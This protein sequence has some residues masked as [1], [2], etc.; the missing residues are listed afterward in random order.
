MPVRIVAMAK[1]PWNST[2]KFRRSGDLG[3]A[4]FS[5][6]TWRWW[7]RKVGAEFVLLE[8][9]LGGEG[10]HNIPPTV[11]RWLALQDLFTC[12]GSDAQIAM[13]DADTMV[14]WD[15]PD[16][17]AFAGPHLAAVRD[18]YGTW[19]YKSIKA[20]QY[21][22]PDVNLRWWEYF[23]SG[24]VVLTYDHLEMA[25]AVTDIAVSRQRE[26]MNL[27]TPWGY[28]DDQT[29]MNYV[30]QQRQIRITF[31]DPPYNMVRCVA[32]TP[33]IISLEN[34]PPLFKNGNRTRKLL[35]PQPLFIEMAYV[36]HFTNVHRCRSLIMQETWDHVS[37]QYPGATVV[38][39]QVDY[40]SCNAFS[41]ET[42]V[43]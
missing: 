6:I 18:P 10:F 7:C 27:S 8:Q 28:G 29:L 26:L 3:Y 36:W 32:M 43:T 33:E 25:Q 31:L 37:A 23:N 17:F 9:P 24:L 16:F 22:F 11:Q 34:T 19:I 13:V 39:E 20:H 15:T 41:E 42:E 14:R 5:E 2:T 4:Q 1:I 30:V 35:S 12:Y 21:L 38:P 40:P